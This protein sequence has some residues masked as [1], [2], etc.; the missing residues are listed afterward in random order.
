MT[1]LTQPT[2]T[3][4]LTQEFL[5]TRDREIISRIVNI[6]AHE[7]ITIRIEAGITVWVRVLGGLLPFD[8]DWFAL[9]VAE[10]KAEM[11]AET[12]EHGKEDMGDAI[13]NICVA[14]ISIQASLLQNPNADL[15]KKIESKLMHS[16]DFAL[17]KTKSTLLKSA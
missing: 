6:P 15:S 4:T 17:P 12:L 1:T 16:F 11:L 7:I 3:E 10:V 13:P 8:R 14:L 2:A 9:R 5:S